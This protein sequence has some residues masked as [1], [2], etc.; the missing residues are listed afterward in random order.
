[1]PDGDLFRDWIYRNFQLGPRD[2]SARVEVMTEMGAYIEDALRDRIA[3]PK[4]DMLTLVANAEIDGEPVDWN[5]KVGY[6][7]LLIVAGIDGLLDRLAEIPDAEEFLD[8]FASFIA[9]HGHR[10]PNDWELSARTW[11]N[12]PE[13]AIDSMRR[14]DHDLSPDSRL[15]DDEA[16]RRAAVAKVRPGVSWK[17]R[18]NFDRAV[19]AMPY[20]AQGRESTRDSA[21]RMMLPVKQ[22]YRELVRRAA[23]HGGDPD[24][25]RVA[26]L[27]PRTEFRQYLQDPSSMADTINERALLHARYAAVVPRFFITSQSDIPTLEEL[28]AEQPDRGGPAEVGDVLTGDAGSSG[29]ARGKA[30]VILD[31]ADG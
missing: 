9:E 6:V 2:N 14:S 13:L 8:E 30:R 20:W 12:T 17:D 18:M 23:E 15:H 22:V 28:E 7:R 25:V 29:V 26:L 31:P 1:M 16:K 3:N 4:D 11:D 5:L 19:K 24:P 21:V 10:G 27:D